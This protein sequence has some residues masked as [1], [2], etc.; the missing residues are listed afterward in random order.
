MGEPERLGLPAMLHGGKRRVVALVG[1]QDKL[2]TVSARLESLHRARLLHR[3]G[4][5]CHI[6]Y[7]LAAG[8]VS[9]LPRDALDHAAERAERL[10]LPLQPP[11]KED[12]DEL[13]E[14]LGSQS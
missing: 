1:E 2:G 13:S 6:H 10:A 4:E 14:T 9:G 8:H 12:F 11:R 5:A 7:R 3:R